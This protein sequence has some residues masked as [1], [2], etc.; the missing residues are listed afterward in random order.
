MTEGEKAFCRRR[1]REELSLARTISCAE[2]KVL[3]LQWAQ[4][5]Q[6]RLDGKRTSTPPPLS[7][8]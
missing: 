7:H 8:H 6:H 1:I 4:F 5:F 2:T 3:H